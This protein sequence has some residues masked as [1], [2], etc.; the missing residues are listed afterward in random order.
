MK[1]RL[2]PALLDL[3]IAQLGAPLDRRR[4]VLAAL[5][6]AITIVLLVGAFTVVRE[7][8]EPIAAG[9]ATASVSGETLVRRA[10][11][12]ES[13][14]LR[15]GSTIGSGD[16]IEVLS[17]TTVLRLA[18]GTTIEGRAFGD[19]ETFLEFGAVP[20][21]RG[22][23]VLVEAPVGYTVEAAGTMIELDGA[24]PAVASVLS[25]LQVTVTTYDGLAVVDSAGQRR[26][27]PALR[28]LTVSSLG[29]P[30]TEVDPLQYDTADPWD[31]RYLGEAIDTGR[32]LDAFDRA[33]TA[34]I[35]P[36]IAA[37]PATYRALLPAL[38]DEPAFTVLLETGRSA[39]EVVVGAAIA[40]RA[41]G[42]TFGERWNATFRFRDDGAEWGLVALDQGADPVLVLDDVEAAIAIATAPPVELA[43]TSEPG[44]VPAPVEVPPPPPPA[45][46]DGHLHPETV[47][48]APIAPPPGPGTTP[49]PPVSP[50]LP[51]A[52]LLT[53][54][55]GPTLSPT[56]APSILGSLLE[57]VNDLLGA[58]LDG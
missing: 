52:P 4:P 15:D 18:D 29:R 54:G 42:R 14:A 47:E 55:G 19:R 3:R 45:D 31:L 43:V 12:S 30:A 25:T 6:T 40:A 38:V 20:V 5:S 1:D 49:A 53:P 21:L 28:Q 33:A 10:G 7:Q 36:A 58:L 2:D 27:V 13:Q 24:A 51:D 16:E 35:P 48:P 11:A 39:G 26:D 17:G 56:P 34:V 8:V 32:R 46:P 41:E 37:D 57:P 44:P 22:G 9:E 50:L 23:E